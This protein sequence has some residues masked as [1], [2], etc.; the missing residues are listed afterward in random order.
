MS[1]QQRGKRLFGLKSLPQISRDLSTRFW[2][3]PRC[4]ARLLDRLANGGDARRR[5]QASAE[6]LG[7]LMIVRVDP[8]VCQAYTQ[9]L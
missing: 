5:L 3:Q 9:G 1:R 6:S 7:C 2:Q 4:E 8:A